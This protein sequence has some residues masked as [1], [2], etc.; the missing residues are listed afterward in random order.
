MTNVCGEHL[1]SQCFD[2]FFFSD[3]FYSYTPPSQPPAH[4]IRM[5][6]KKVKDTALYDVLGVEPTA[7]DIECVIRFRRKK[8]F[9]TDHQAQEGVQ[10]ARHQGNLRSDLDMT[11]LIQSITQIK[12]RLPRPSPSSRKSGE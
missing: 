6:T 3:R 11:S 9:S 10:E 1:H 4:S 8:V 2:F 12:T 7:T 5:A